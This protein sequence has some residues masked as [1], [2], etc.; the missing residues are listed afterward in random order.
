MA[1][2]IYGGFC[3][4]FDAI[5]GNPPWDKTKFS[6]SDFFPQFN[7][8]YRSLTESKKREIRHNLTQKPYIANEFAEKKAEV[9]AQNNYYKAHFPL[10]GGSGDGN[11]F[12]FFVEQDLGLLVEGAT[13][14]YVLPS[15]LMLEM[16]SESLRREILEHRTL[17]FFYGFENRKGIFHDVHRS[18]KFALMQIQNRAPTPSHAVKTMFYKTDIAEVQGELGKKNAI[19]L[20]L[21]EIKA[22]SPAQLSLHEVRGARDLEILKKCYGRFAPLDSQWLDF[23]NELHMTADKDLFIEKDDPKKRWHAGLLRL[24]EGK[25]IGQ[26]N[27]AHGEMNGEA[28]YFLDA[29]DFD[30]RLRTKEI[31]R[32]KGDLERV[33]GKKLSAK[34]YEKLLEIAYPRLRK[35]AAE[36]SFIAYDRAFWRLGFRAIASDTN[37]RTL[38]FSLLPKNCGFGHSMFANSPKIY[39]L[40]SAAGGGITHTTISPLRILFALGVFNAIIIDFLARGMI[41]I[42]VS[43]TYLVRLPLPQPSDEE[44]RQDSRYSFIAHTAL[45]LQLYNDKRGEFSEL[46]AAFGVQKSDLPDS[47]K[48]YDTLRAKL[49]I[50]AAKLYGISRDEMGYVLESFKVLRDKQPGF[51]GRLTNEDLW[52]ECDGM[53]RESGD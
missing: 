10:N 17:Q 29:R 42:N 45:K 22:L 38:I 8:R 9:E 41:Q 32:V 3:V 52:A 49:D 31:F 1:A 34:G 21:E 2:A 46:A 13:L 25:M 7:S 48:D 19:P 5:I 6:E 36:D 33:S 26:F 14:N 20:T 16:G 4:G 53:W 23:R 44:I 50:C 51:C 43:K 39:A 12:R 11:L 24:F 27:A 37:E 30:A 28:Q 18:Y 40:D 15:A 47:S 35:A